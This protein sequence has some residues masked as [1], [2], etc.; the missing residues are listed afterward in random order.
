MNDLMTDWTHQ[1]QL[2]APVVCR[3]SQWEQT[4][5][6]GADLSERNPGKLCLPRGVLVTTR[7]YNWSREFWSVPKLIIQRRMGLWTLVPVHSAQANWDIVQS[8]WSKGRSFSIFVNALNYRRTGKKSSLVTVAF[9]FIATCHVDL[10]GG[11]FPWG[12]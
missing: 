7:L 5:T 9:W 6:W 3:R 8:W 11:Q 12:L 10:F 4:L 1:R 2:T